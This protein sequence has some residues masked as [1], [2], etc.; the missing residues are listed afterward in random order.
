MVSFNSYVGFLVYQRVKLIIISVQSHCNAYWKPSIKAMWLC[1]KFPSD[2]K[3]HMLH[4]A[5]ICTSMT[6]WFLG[7]GKCWYPPVIKHGLLENEPVISDL[8]K[9]FISMRPTGHLSKISDFPAMFD[10]HFG[11]FIFQH[12]HGSLRGA[13]KSNRSP[14]QSPSM[15]SP[16]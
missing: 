12:H 15:I 2:V 10:D 8:K 6:G 4:G 5:H 1:G 16:L 7:N 11:N 14:R 9:T 13:G 3:T